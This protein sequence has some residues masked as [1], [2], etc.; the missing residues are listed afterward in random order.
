MVSFS[1]LCHWND[2]ASILQSQSKEDNKVH[3]KTL[4]KDHESRMGDSGVNTDVLSSGNAEH[5]GGG[6][7]IVLLCRNLV[8]PKYF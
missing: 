8:F 4:M 7:L 3:V 1:A 2:S 6:M 5:L